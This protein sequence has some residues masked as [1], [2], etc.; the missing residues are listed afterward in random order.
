MKNRLVF[1]LLIL[2]LIIIHP[3]SA[4]QVSKT[5][6][7]VRN[8]IS[9]DVK[10]MEVV[11]VIKMLATRSGMNIIVGKNV[12][13][14]VT[15][16]LKEVDIW[17]AFEIV[18][19]ANDL[20]YEKQG[21]IINVMTQR[22]YEALYGK[23][24]QDNKQVQVIKLQ[25]AKAVDISRALGQM[26]SD[27]G[28]VVLD[29]S[30]NTI[31][32]IDSPERIKAMELFVKETDLPLETRVLSL[33]YAPVDKL[34]SKIQEAIT[35]GM[36]SIKIDERTNKIAVTDYPAKLSEIAKLI[37]AFDEKTAQVLIDSQIIEL[38]PSD[39]FEMGINLDYWIKKYFEVQ[40]S[41]PINTTNTLLIGTTSASPTQKGQ[42]KAIIDIL[43]TIGDTKIL[44]SPRI[45]TLNNQEAKILVGTKDAYI[46]STTSLGGSGTTVT[47]QSVNFV[48]TGI[49]LHVT[50]TINKDSFVTMKIR[51]EVSS[52]VMTNIKSED[53]ITQIPIVTTSEAETT[54][55]VKDGVTIVIGGL[56]KDERNKTIKK[57]PL[58]GDI[59]GLGYFFRSTSDETSKTELVILLT[60]H[61][62]SGEKAYAD[63]SEIRPKDGAIVRMI[64]GD[65]VTER[66][67]ERAEKKTPGNSEYKYYRLL[68]EK[69]KA[70]TLFDSAGGE[71]G[72]VNVSFILNSNG[73]VKDEPVILS[74]TNPVLGKI[75]TEAIK[76]ASSFPPFPKE[77]D[78]AEEIFRVT[79]DYK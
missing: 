41:L 9:L 24:Y 8:K 45:M 10:G 7:S 44:S 29:E 46:T 18:I 75:V 76:R 3:A 68:T 39:K 55:M 69:V 34:G 57:I 36:G 26:K 6:L 70:L 58:L 37:S 64:K 66:I 59:P 71:K 40:A 23:R 15:L 17:D 72:S 20:A 47:S 60:P 48:D 50:P 32:F 35:K 73:E 62:M 16:F 25:Y 74:S 11:D 52:A 2:T 42:Y 14:R 30:S 67:R 54:I 28:R 21:E 19:L 12:T 22:D 56:R 63:F 31:A 51:P 79:L 5:G 65:I 13:G 77:M 27:S 78:K 43:R 49:K 38:T 33:N 53:K 1:I 61:I 4:Q